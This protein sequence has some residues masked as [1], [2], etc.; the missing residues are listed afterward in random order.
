MPVPLN[1]LTRAFEES[2]EEI[3]AQV[4]EVVRSGRYLG[5]DRVQA[6]ARAFAAYIG[7]SHCV[8][9]GNGTDALELALKVAALTLELPEGEVLTVANA[10][11]YATTAILRNHLR[12]VL[13]DVVERSQLMSIDAAVALLSE[14]TVAIVATHL[15][16]GFLDVDQL[17]DA[18]VRAGYGHVLIVEDCCQSHGLR[19]GGRMTGSM[20]D[21]A[22]FSFYPTKNLGAFGDAGA[23]VTSSDELADKVARLRQY[24]W[25]TTAKYRIEMDGGRNSRMDEIQ[26]AVLLVQLARLEGWNET[27][28]SIL[29][30]LQQAAP[31]DVT[32]V[33][34]ELGGVAHLAVAMCEDRDGLRQHLQGHGIATDVHYPILDCDQPAWR[35]RLGDQRRNLPVASRSSPRLLTLPCFPAMTDGEIDQ[36]CHALSS[37]R[38]A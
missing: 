21:M 6:F 32:F 5:G 22:A 9:V 30:R 11:G 26:A 31:Q 13:V 8:P 35:E 38:R 29:D 34:S 18:L 23:V 2:R 10:G 7:V 3:E 17:R 20:G 37:W 27:R 12:P 16:G 28:R 33:R 25:A 36:V 15:Y 24:G 4:L 1:D 19:S 14:R